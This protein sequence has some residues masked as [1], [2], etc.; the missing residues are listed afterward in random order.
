MKKMRKLWVVSVLTLGM[1]ASSLVFADDGNPGPGIGG[2]P[3]STPTA[4]IILEEF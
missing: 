2:S 4:T 3:G 1:L